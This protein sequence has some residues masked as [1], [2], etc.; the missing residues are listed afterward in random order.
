MAFY[1]IQ[2]SVNSSQNMQDTLEFTI[3]RGSMP[4]GPSHFYDSFQPPN[5][6]HILTYLYSCCILG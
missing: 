6:K 4:L 2:N 5:M 3:L 1:N